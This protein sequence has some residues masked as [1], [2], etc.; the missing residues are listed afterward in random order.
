MSY[1]VQSSYRNGSSDLF[2]PSGRYPP[3]TLYVMLSPHGPFWRRCCRFDCAAVGRA[4]FFCIGPRLGLV[5]SIYHTILS[6]FFAVFFLF[7]YILFKNILALHICTTYLQYIHTPLS[8]SISTSP[9]T[10]QHI[11]NQCPPPSPPK[12]PLL[13]TLDTLGQTLLINPLHALR[14]AEYIN[15][16]DDLGVTLLCK[17]IHQLRSASQYIRM[18]V[19]QHNKPR[20]CCSSYSRCSRSMCSYYARSAGGDTRLISRGGTG[21]NPSEKSHSK[22]GSRKRV[23]AGNGRGSLDPSAR[24]RRRKRRSSRPEGHTRKRRKTVSR[25]DGNEM[26]ISE[27]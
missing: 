18:A 7:R 21:T 19:Q 16:L 5:A 15:L 8:T 20:D 25:A 1:L 4:Y 10:K 12:M 26:V 14:T 27:I 23:E 9:S 17:P 11:Y 13:T 2:G 24:G 6:V 3:T 22:S